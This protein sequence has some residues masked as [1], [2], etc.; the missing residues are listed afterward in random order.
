MVENSEAIPL[1]MENASPLRER[2]I[3]FLTQFQKL[4]FTLLLKR[5]YVYVRD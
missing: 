5:V 4:E 1:T 2:T 3:N